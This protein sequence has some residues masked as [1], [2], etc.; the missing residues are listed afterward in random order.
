MIA[1]R[2]GVPV[3]SSQIRFWRTPGRASIHGRS[4]SAKIC[5]GGPLARCAS[6]STPPVMIARTVAPF[7]ADTVWT[8]P[9]GR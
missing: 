6:G 9:F 5:D 1:R 8:Q 2:S 7:G 3:L 4:L